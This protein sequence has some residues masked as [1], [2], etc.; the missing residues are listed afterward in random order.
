MSESPIQAR[1]FLPR[2]T[3]TYIQRLR[4][5]DVGVASESLSAA[6]TW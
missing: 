1:E 5:R 2:P 6:A 3:E 4:N